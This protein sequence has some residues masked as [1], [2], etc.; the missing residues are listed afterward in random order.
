MAALA[1]ELPGPPTVNTYYRHVGPRVLISRE[2]RRFREKIVALMRGCRRLRG[3]VCLTGDFFPPDRRRRDLDN[4][5]GKALLDALK[6]AG[7]YEDDS[8][9]KRMVLQMREPM[10]PDGAC[11]LKL[12]EMDE[13]D[14]PECSH[15]DERR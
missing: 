3:P 12:E 15:A 13:H 5:A 4:V 9:V 7:A 6:Y 14:E 1:V 2:G 8:Q 10:P 11:Y